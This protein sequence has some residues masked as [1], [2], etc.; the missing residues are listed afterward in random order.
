[1]GRPGPRRDEHA[2]RGGDFAAAS[3]LYLRASA[4]RSLRDWKAES[5]ELGGREELAPYS[6]FRAALA[7]QRSGDQG[8]FIALLTQAA[9]RYDST[10]H[11]AAAGAYLAALDEGGAPSA[12]C[13]AAE[14]VLLPVADRFALIWDYGFANPEHAITGICR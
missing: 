8:S 9:T 10:L 5:G 2:E 4:E 13:A 12:A 14:G 7:T 11:G 3:Q 6:L 1:M